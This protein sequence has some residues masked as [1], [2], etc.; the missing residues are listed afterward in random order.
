VL[1]CGINSWPREVN[2]CI[3]TPKDKCPKHLCICKEQ[4]AGYDAKAEDTTHHNILCQ[5]KRKYIKETGRLLKKEAETFP[6]LF[7]K[8]HLTIKEML[9]NKPFTCKCL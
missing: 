4:L 6:I 9:E 5:Y 2:H 1:W 3:L 8:G 7:P